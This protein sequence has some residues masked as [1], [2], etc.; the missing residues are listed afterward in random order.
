[1]MPDASTVSPLDLTL[2]GLPLWRIALAVIILAAGVA[3]RFVLGA[4]LRS[5]IE[6]L[7]RRTSSQLDDR[8]GEAVEPPLL[9]LPIAA[10]VFF[11]AQTL[12][13]TGWALE[14]ANNVAG[15]LLAITFFWA[16]SRL[17]EPMAVMVRETERLMTPSLVNWAHKAAR[18]LVWAVGVATILELWGIRVLPLIAGF[19]LLGVAVAL[20][21]QDL[22]KNLISGVLIITEKR[23]RVGDWVKGDGVEGTVELIGFRSTKIRQFD[24]APVY[25]PNN[26]LADG[27]VV[28]FG[29]M[30]HR[31]IFWMIG[32][33]YRTTAGQLSRIRD[34]IEQLIIEDE[35]YLDPPEGTR[36][37]RLD[38]F[39]D[40]S[41]DLMIYCFTETRVWSEWLLIKEELLLAIKTIVE[42]EGAGFAFPSRSVYLEAT[43]ENVTPIAAVAG[44]AA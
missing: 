18:F 33:E 25:V 31:R 41:I 42:E 2:F 10:G 11:A 9:F 32:L 15:T 19:G 36:L 37:V 43:P 13:L 24:K 8:I 27:A 16:L 3:L 22:F 44:A 12:V 39:S 28:N 26:S 4:V 38:R 40:S 34:R 7:T 20:G 21:A 23:F 29:E 35:R 6:A 17:V 5:W 1:M 14:A 30:T